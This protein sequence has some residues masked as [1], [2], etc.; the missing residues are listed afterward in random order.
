MFINEA[1]QATIMN[2]QISMCIL[3]T[4]YEN[5]TD[6]ILYNDNLQLIREAEE[7]K[8]Q[9]A[10]AW[11]KEKIGKFIS[12]VKGWLEKLKTFIFKTIPE[13][14]KNKWNKLLIFLKIKKK[15]VEVDKPEEV[16]EEEAKKVVAMA[17][18]N[19]NAQAILSLIQA[20]EDA[21]DNKAA[22][23]N[24][25][26]PHGVTA[27]KAAKLKS[28]SIKYIQNAMKNAK[29]NT[30]KFFSDM[31]KSIQNNQ[32]VYLSLAGKSSNEEIKV[33]IIDINLA[34]SAIG[35]HTGISNCISK[36]TTDF[37][38]L[39]GD[40]LVSNINLVDSDSP[41][42]NKQLNTARRLEKEFNFDN[43]RE[44]YKLPTTQELIASRKEVVINSKSLA[45]IFSIKSLVDKGGTIYQK[46]YSEASK[47]INS[48]LEQLETGIKLYE[49]NK[50]FQ[51]I[52]N[53]VVALVKSLLN[54][55]SQA[56]KNLMDL[57][58]IVVEDVTTALAKAK[59]EP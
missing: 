4:Q 18:K 51:T 9:K 19:A 3:Q 39:M 43:I 31:I 44:K 26:S 10:G 38:R 22:L 20:Q 52:A 45:N 47:K 7:S 24:E 36:Y 13:F 2:Q 15:P 6:K 42:F 48:S 34:A 30:K 49:D 35:R 28:E 37:T 33:N 58:K 41:E 29:P 57:Q 59:P 23:T 16:S 46:T 14:I 56:S 55:I 17:N 11:I 8:L 40:T 50:K 53:T 32:F 1:Y 12:L 25:T 5:A 27:A 21:N 54:S